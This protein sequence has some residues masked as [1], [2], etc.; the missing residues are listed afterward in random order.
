MYKARVAQIADRI[1]EALRARQMRPSALC[2]VAKIPQSS[3]SLYLSGAYEPKQDRVYA[4]AAALNVDVSW[5]LGYDVPMGTFAENLVQLDTPTIELVSV[6][7]NEGKINTP[8]TQKEM[9]M[10]DLFRLLTEEEQEHVLQTAK[11]I[12]KQ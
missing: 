4:M 12:A 6:N 1:G 8:V 9:Q 2:K 5:L 3:L 10:L 7:I 11:M